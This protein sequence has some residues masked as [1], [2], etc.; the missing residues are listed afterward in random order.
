ME[1]CVLGWPTLRY[2]HGRERQYRMAL[3]ILLSCTVLCPKISPVLGNSNY[4]LVLVLAAP[5]QS[6]TIFTCW[7]HDMALLH[8]L[9]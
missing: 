6:E 4:L 8:L 9:G 3:A 2:V 5:H 7:A 1:Q